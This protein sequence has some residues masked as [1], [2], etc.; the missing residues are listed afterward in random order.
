MLTP[1]EEN[2]FEHAEQP[3]SSNGFRLMLSFQGGLTRHSSLQR[4]KRENT[5]V[6]SG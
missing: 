2:C 4:C 6:D 3:Y 5:D 1:Y